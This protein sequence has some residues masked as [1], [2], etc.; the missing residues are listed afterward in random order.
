M[1]STTLENLCQYVKSPLGVSTLSKRQIYTIDYGLSKN[2]SL[3]ADVWTDLYSRR[4]SKLG[5]I[6]LR[7]APDSTCAAHILDDLDPY[8]INESLSLAN[9]TVMD[10]DT[11]NKIL[12]YS[13]SEAGASCAGACIVYGLAD[14]PRVKALWIGV[15]SKANLENGGILYE[16]RYVVEAAVSKYNLLQDDEII[17]LIT[18]KYG[19]VSSVGVARLLDLKPSLIGKLL[20]ASRGSMIGKFYNDIALTRHISQ[21]QA[22]EIYLGCLKVTQG[23]GPDRIAS[24]L[25]TSA[26]LTLSKNPSVSHKIRAGALDLL[27]NDLE[28]GSLKQDA[29]DRLK[30]EVAHAISGKAR[31]GPDWGGLYGEELVE[32]VEFLSEDLRAFSY[33]TLEGTILGKYE[34]NKMKFAKEYILNVLS[35]KLDALGVTGWDLF[36]DLC[37]GWHGTVEDLLEIV[38]STSSR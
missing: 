9:V 1:V 15:T 37:V 12:E 30:S 18:S 6:L 14:Q 20:M 10:L 38:S 33:P 5:I 11:K 24:I 36:I 31:L 19:M 3:P 7:S 16:N 34:T 17:E 25:I 23:V 22:E 29:E 28:I 32:V 8:I 13:L 35:P 26:L 4:K 2:E 27:V 21:E